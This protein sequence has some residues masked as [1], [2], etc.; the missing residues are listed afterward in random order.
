M[1]A[2][3]AVDL[4]VLARVGQALADDSRRRLLVALLDGSRYP[5]ELADDLGLSR[6][7]VS[8]H[9]T[10]LR[11]CGLISA[12]AEGRRMRYELAD[13]RLVDVLHQLCR[14]V[15]PPPRGCDHER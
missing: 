6:T 3:T 5:S 11:G 13:D 9:L 1:T 12:T 8:N 14:L 2:T 15:L 7:N 10:C 4:D